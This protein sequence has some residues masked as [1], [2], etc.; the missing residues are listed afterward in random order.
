MYRDTDLAGPHTAARQ[1]AA[2]QHLDQTW[3]WMNS[4]QACGNHILGN[5]GK[6]CMADRSPTGRWP[7]QVW[8]R[9]TIV[10][11]SLNLRAPAPLAQE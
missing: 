5:A 2:L 11:N 3:Y 7:W 10:S 9:D 8:Y 6:A 1:K 4:S